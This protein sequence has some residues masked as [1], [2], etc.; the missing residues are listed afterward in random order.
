MRESFPA[1]SPEAPELRRLRDSPGRK[2]AI[3]WGNKSVKY[4][5][6]AHFSPRVNIRPIAS[7]L[8]Q[9]EKMRSLLW[10]DR[11]ELS[12][13]RR[14]QCGI[15]KNLPSD[16]HVY[17][18]GG[19]FLHLYG[20]DTEEGR[21]ER[22]RRVVDSIKAVLNEQARQSRQNKWKKSSERDMTPMFMIAIQY[23]W[24]TLKALETAKTRAIQQ[25][26]ELETLWRNDELINAEENDLMSMGEVVELLHTATG[27]DTSRPLQDK[28]RY[29]S[30]DERSLEDTKLS[31]DKTAKS[32]ASKLDNPAVVKVKCKAT[33]RKLII[34]NRFFQ[35]IHGKSAMDRVHNVDM[36]SFRGTKRR[37][38]LNDI[39]IPDHLLDM[40]EYDSDEEKKHTEKCQ[41]RLESILLT[42][43][44]KSTRPKR[45]IQ[46]TG[47]VHRVKYIPI[48]PD[49]SEKIAYFYT[50]EEINNFRFEKFMEDHGDEFEEILEDEADGDDDEYEYEDVSYHSDSDEEESYEEEVVEVSPNFQRLS[51]PLSAGGTNRNSV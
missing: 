4:K 42:P 37:S 15:T 40:Y 7:R 22:Y 26:Q 8:L 25:T 38:F 45:N 21:L 10:Y 51:Q 19:F 3:Q 23:S 20:M 27:H 13:M 36:K 28:L 35:Q 16:D 47:K 1:T 43:E 9:S 24:H 33:I 34:L 49:E 14:D 50:S 48:F 17:E 32:Q 18:E 31:L 46:W 29:L 30:P 44:T 6:S 2:I 11:D 5:K 39:R 12:R 41:K